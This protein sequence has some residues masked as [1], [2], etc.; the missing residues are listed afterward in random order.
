MVEFW[1]NLIYNFGVFLYE[2]SILKNI[3]TIMTGIL[4][5]QYDI[6]SKIYTCTYMNNSSNLY[7]F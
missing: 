1:S 2:I 6:F 5:D 4:I 3:W 7:Y